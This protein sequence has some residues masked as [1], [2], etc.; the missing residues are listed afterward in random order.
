[1]NMKMQ[2]DFAVVSTDNKVAWEELREVQN[3]NEFKKA[4]KN[5]KVFADDQSKMFHQGYF[6]QMR[7][8]WPHTQATKELFD[9]WRSRL[10][11][12]E[13]WKELQE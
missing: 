3:F 5:F 12:T 4:Y 6:V 8:E 1:M 11:N 7:L 13:Y 10:V 9:E 2:I